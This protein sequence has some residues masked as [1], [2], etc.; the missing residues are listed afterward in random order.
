LTVGDRARTF[1]TVAKFWEDSKA[2]VDGPP[3][4]VWASASMAHL[5]ALAHRNGYAGARWAKK[6]NA[7]GHL[8]IA[9][10]LPP[11]HEGEWAA[12]K[13]DAREAKRLERQKR[14]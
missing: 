7:A 5:E 14:S 3:L 1:S 2:D 11:R 6:V 10:V 12:P 13:V 8:V 9:L 4:P